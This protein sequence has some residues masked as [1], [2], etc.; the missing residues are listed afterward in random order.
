M[1]LGSVKYSRERIYTDK[2]LW[3]FYFHYR[4]AAFSLNNILQA[5]PF[6]SIAVAKGGGSYIYGQQK[7]TND[8]YDFLIKEAE[9]ELDT[10]SKT[11]VYID[12]QNKSS[13][14]ANNDLDA[15]LFESIKEL[16][17]NIGES[18]TT[19]TGKD[20]ANKK[21]VKTKKLWKDHVADALLATSLNKTKM[22]GFLKTT[23]GF[24]TLVNMAKKGQSRPIGTRVG[25]VFE[26]LAVNILDDISKNIGNGILSQVNNIKGIGVAKSQPQF[27][28]NNN[29]LRASPNPLTITPDMI[30]NYRDSGTGM[31]RNINVS[32]K[33]AQDPQKVTFKT[34][35][36]AY[37]DP[38]TRIA[39]WQRTM[40]TL[41]AYGSYNE[42]MDT[43]SELNRFV[44]A[45]F[46]SIAIGGFKE[47]RA[48]FLLTYSGDRINI[49][50]LDM[51]LRDVKNR[52]VIKELTL[53]TESQAA[54]IDNARLIAG[55][56]LNDKSYPGQIKSSAVY[57]SL[58][59]L[60]FNYSI[61]TI[62]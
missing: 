29:I 53:R 56:W 16:K 31:N 50:S 38:I 43:G 34:F 51:A 13:G 37:G 14:R 54:Y 7:S 26:N 28:G 9:I 22:E 24:S 2:D 55:S 23:K 45:T 19:R 18:F 59:D 35:S 8:V 20:L 5:F 47:N 27:G 4:K 46:A 42:L 33:L 57:T 1:Q 62:V 58:K 40:K 39:L 3:Q 48:H 49:K 17:H 41:V 36:G 6:K 12:S 44:A 25:D 21:I 60:N 61:K 11:N 15:M 30:I 10:D 32:I 52:M